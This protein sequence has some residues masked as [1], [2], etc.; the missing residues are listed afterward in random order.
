V[1]GSEVGDFI[2][3][4]WVSHFWSVRLAEVMFA[5]SPSPQGCPLGRFNRSAGG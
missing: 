3:S 1:R 4:D 2:V 5:Y